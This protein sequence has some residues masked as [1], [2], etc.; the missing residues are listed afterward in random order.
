MDAMY[1]TQTGRKD[2]TMT[3]WTERMMSRGIERVVDGV[4]MI[5]DPA[6]KPIRQDE[7]G[8]A[9]KRAKAFYKIQKTVLGCTTEEQ[10]EVCLNMVKQYE[11]LMLDFY[12]TTI[13]TK[14]ETKR[15]AIELLSL[16][17]LKRRMIRKG[18]A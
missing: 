14:Q 13:P 4:C 18:K 7:K 8:F 2:T 6:M 10:L 17:K 3:I 16:I 15:S 11:R 1:T 12:H 9:V 5:I